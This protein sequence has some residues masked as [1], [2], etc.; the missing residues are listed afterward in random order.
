MSTKRNQRQL[1]KDRRTAQALQFSQALKSRNQFILLVCLGIA[2]ALLLLAAAPVKAGG[3]GG[4]RGQVGGYS[5]GYG[6]GYNNFEKVQFIAVEEDPYSV[7]IVGENLRAQYRAEAASRQAQEALASINGGLNSEIS[8]L[9]Q[10]VQAL[11]AAIGGGGHSQPAPTTSTPRP[12]PQAPAPEA[13]DTTPAPTT[14]TSTS[15]PD[16]VNAAW[17]LLQERCATCHNAG[18]PGGGFSLFASAQANDDGNWTRAKM[19]AGKLILIDHLTYANEMP[20]P[21][22]KKLDSKEYNLLR[23]WIQESSE[24][25]REVARAAD[26]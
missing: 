3:N 11:R 2:A 22:H 6:N 25:I 26:K 24:D 17:N 5:G 10:E 8:L 14:S 18:K 21:P 23:A 1:V 13:E 19:N 16:L 9:R 12:T 7:E 15:D 4:Y 20:K